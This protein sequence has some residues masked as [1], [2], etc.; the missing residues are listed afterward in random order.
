MPGRPLLRKVNKVIEENGGEDAVVFDRIAEGVPVGEIASELPCSRQYLYMWR[1]EKGH[2][3]R[4]QE[5]W[6]RAMEAR[7]DDMLEESIQIL[8]DLHEKEPDPTT[9]QVSLAGRRADQRIGLA[10]MMNPEKYG[11]KKDSVEVNFNLGELHLGALQKHGRMIPAE[12]QEQVE[13]ADYE[14]LEGE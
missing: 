10:K 11:D 4:R 9:A 1:D 5:K 8:D 2:R 7:T 3:E 14:M 12:E 13:E 6:K